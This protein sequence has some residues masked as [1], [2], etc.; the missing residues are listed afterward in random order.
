M[1][2]ALIDARIARLDDAARDLIVYASATVRDFRPELLG[3]AMDLPEARLLERIDRLERGGLLKPSG[4]GR[5]DFAH[6]LIRQAT[7]RSLSQPRR[8]LI[9]GPGRRRGDRA[10]HAR[11]RQSLRAQVSPS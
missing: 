5:F 8:R 1:Q 9:I 2:C 4:E 10:R 6:D 7:Y 3:A 11:E